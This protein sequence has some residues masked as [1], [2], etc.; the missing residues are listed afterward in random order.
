M[1]KIPPPS[2]QDYLW[3]SDF[4][5]SNCFLLIFHFEVVP[6]WKS[7]IYLVGNLKYIN[8]T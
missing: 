5:Y 4:Q 6:S 7:N 1:E 2:T 3:L 8:Y